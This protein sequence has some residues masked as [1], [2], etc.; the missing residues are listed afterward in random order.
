MKMQELLFEL[1]QKPDIRVYAAQAIKDSTLIPM[2]L[3]I[4]ETDKTAVKFT[5]EKIIREISETEPKALFP[6]FER[7]EKLL[8]S[9]NNFIKWGFIL[10]LT[11]IINLDTEHKFE[12]IADKYISL[13]DSDSVVTFSNAV[14]NLHKLLSVYS[15][16]ESDIMAKLLD[17]DRH[18]FLYK[19]EVSPECNNVA[20]GHIIDCFEKLYD[21]SGYKKEIIEFICGSIDNERKQVRLKAARFLK[22]HGVDL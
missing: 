4:I 15:N 18:V 14:N 19:G 17:I 13:L 6:Y 8:D 20:K 5:C 11:N 3:D 21:K 16:H 7:M 9:E 1:K 12:A 22:N 10:S 2:L